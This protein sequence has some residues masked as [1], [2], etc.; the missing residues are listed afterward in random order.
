MK[1]SENVLTWNH[2]CKSTA[3]M[4]CWGPEVLPGNTKF[5]FIVWVLPDVLT[6]LKLSKTWFHEQLWK[7]MHV[8]VETNFQLLE[9][10]TIAYPNW[11][12]IRISGWRFDLPPYWR[13]LR[14]KS[15]NKPAV[16]FYHWPYIPRALIPARSDWAFNFKKY[17]ISVN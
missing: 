1:W 4:N 7:K 10:R 12:L 6:A 13:P 5:F 8:E 17:E 3:T 9:E 14:S 11:V 15:W 16:S 2:I